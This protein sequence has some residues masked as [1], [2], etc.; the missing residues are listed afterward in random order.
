E[1]AAGLPEA[2]SAAAPSF[3]LGTLRGSVAPLERLGRAEPEF[4]SGL[5]A[6]P[7]DGLSREPA[8]PAFAGA[9][10]R[11]SGPALGLEPPEG[12]RESARASR[13]SVAG[14]APSLRGPPVFSLRYRLQRG[15]ARL[16]AKLGLAASAPRLPASDYEALVRHYRGELP[17]LIILDYDDTF[18][19]NRDGKGMQ[20]SAEKV[21]LL[22]RLHAVGIR[23]AFATNRPMHG[24]GFGINEL[25]MDRLPAPLRRGFLLSAGGGSELYR[26]GPEGET[27]AAPA[28]VHALSPTQVAL[29]KRLFRREAARFG[30]TRGQEGPG[31]EAWEF[32]ENSNGYDYTVLFRPGDGRARAVFERFRAAARRAGLELNMA[33]KDFAADPSRS[34][35]EPLIRVSSADKALAVRD[36][37]ELLAAEGASPAQ[38]DIL[39][40]GDDFARPGFDSAMARA[41]PGATA[42][43]VGL[44][45]DPSLKNV[46]LLPREGPEQTFDLLGRLADAPAQHLETP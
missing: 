40:G 2:L 16:A 9:A 24:K 13:E 28:R 37:L 22:E 15:A 8:A 12:G 19:D 23:V 26:F 31:D 33:V 42:F 14:R 34:H 25:L 18:M 29:L 44:G 36:I 3:S 11:V 45:A 21:R 1:P 10:A 7:F 38:E 20:V 17:R 6:A 32:R 5:A 27:P 41:L 43:A 39:L 30:I 35:L 4:A 46:I